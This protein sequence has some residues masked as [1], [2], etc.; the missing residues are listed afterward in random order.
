VAPVLRG[1]HRFGD[2]VYVDWAGAPLGY[3]DSAAGGRREAH[4]F[5]GALGASDYLFSEAYPDEKL[6]SWLAAHGAMFAFFGGTPGGVVP[7]NPRPAVTAACYYDP[8]LNPAYQEL[9][10]YYGVAVL[11]ARVRRPRDKA[12]V[13]YCAS[14][15]A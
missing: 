6:A 9:A 3:E 10:A 12:N 14:L 15:V 4:L 1:V 2:K 11:P 7:D 8:E 13:A 5:V